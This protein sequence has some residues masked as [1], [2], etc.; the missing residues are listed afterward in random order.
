M[1]DVITTSSCR[2]TIIRTYRSF[3]N[4]VKC[5]GAIRFIVHIDVLHS[6]NLKSLKKF[7]KKLESMR[8]IQV[9]VKINDSPSKN[10]HEAHAKAVSY[11]FS[12][13]ESPYY[14]HLED[15]WVFQKK[16]DLDSLLKLMDER[17]F[18]DHI[19]FNRK[20]IAD[21][22]WLYHLSDEI[23][24]E[25]LFPNHEVVVDGIPLVQVPTWSFNPHLGRTSVI[26]NFVNMKIKE[27]PEKYLC[28]NYP[29]LSGGGKIYLYG[30][31]GDSAFVTDLGRNRIRGILQKYKYIIKGGKYS[32]YKYG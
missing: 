29:K 14:F 19:R 9:D 30:K 1:L 12:R 24:E 32:K 11:L 15:D 16:L 25:Y 18:V 8:G 17:L 5:S 2:K 26:K 13:I 23:S 27:N 31:I 21:K 3:L 28:H 20:T 4:Q 6:E 7:F 10:F 22:S